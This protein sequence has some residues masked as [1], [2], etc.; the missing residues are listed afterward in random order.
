MLQKNIL[1]TWK[2]VNNTLCKLYQT[3]AVRQASFLW[4]KHIIL[5]GFNI[6]L[7]FP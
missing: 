6:Q 7:I 1:L 3:L 4:E 5:T 2:T